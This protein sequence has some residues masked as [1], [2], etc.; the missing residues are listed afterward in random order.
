MD[1]LFNNIRNYFLVPRSNLGITL[2][3]PLYFGA[4]DI[5]GH[6]F[7]IQ[8]VLQTGHI[9]GL[10]S[11]VNFPLFHIYNAIGVEITGLSLR[12]GL[13]VFMGIAWE[14]GI[15]LAYLLFLKISRSRRFAL[16]ATLLLAISPQLILYGSYAITRSLAFVIILCWFY[17]VLNENNINM[18]F[19]L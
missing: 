11:Y 17:L 13:F 3:Y 18:S 5:L 15:L 14:A 7:S 12:T 9:A 19:W 8:T 2:K 4:T 10:E 16:S 1:V 6:L